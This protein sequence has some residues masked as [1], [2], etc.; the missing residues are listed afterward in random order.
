MQEQVLMEWTLSAIAAEVS[1]QLV[2]QWAE[3][4]VADSGAEWF[5]VAV[6]VGFVDNSAA[7]AFLSAE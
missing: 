6:L 5:E 4:L 2:A 3:Q 1:E 7:V